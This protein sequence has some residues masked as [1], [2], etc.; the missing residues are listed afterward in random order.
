MKLYNKILGIQDLSEL[1]TQPQEPQ[2]E[3]FNSNEPAPIANLNCVLLNNGTM[4]VLADWTEQSE[5]MAKTYGKFLYHILSGDAESS[6]LHQLV[7]Y[8]N[9][10]IV[11]QDF[12]SKIIESLEETQNEHRDAPLI[13]PSQALKISD[14]TKDNT[15]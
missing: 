6:I 3:Q 11:R 15:E 10:N 5:G 12:I 2:S 7:I 8:A 9:S 14:M 13:A 1:N 4:Q